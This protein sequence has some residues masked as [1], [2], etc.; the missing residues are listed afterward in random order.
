MAN[1]ASK[2]V[3]GYHD[4]WKA[5]I[6]HLPPGPTTKVVGR[7]IAV[8]DRQV[9]YRFTLH[10]HPYAR[11]L[12]SR[13]IVEGV[14][15]LQAADTER[16]SG[17]LPRPGTIRLALPSG[18]PVPLA[19]ADRV[20]ILDLPAGADDDL[21]AVGTTVTM[22]A[23]AP[24]AA[25]QAAAVT[26]VGVLDGLP[27]LGQDLALP[28]G[29]LVTAGNDLRVRITAET[30]VS[31]G[32]RTV[33]LPAGTVLLVRP[34]TRLTLTALQ[35]MLLDAPPR[36][37]LYGDVLLPGV[38]PYN[39]SY[40]VST[41]YPM[42]DLDFSSGGAYSIYNWELF[43][44]APLTIAMQL[45]KNQR[46]VEAQRWFHYIFD[47]TAD[48]DLP[49]PERFWKVL[50]FHSTQ[51]VSIEHLLTNL[52][53]GDDPELQHETSRS[54]DAWE[55]S[56]FQP[57]V[58]ARY[59]P[60]AYMY[61]AVM[62]YLDNLI[63]WGD[64]YFGEDTPE[65]VDEALQLY[66]LAS[67]IL[68]PRPQVVPR[69]ASRSSA[70]SYHQLRQE[71][72]EF[73][74]AMQQL[75]S[76]LPFD[77]MPSS[78]ADGSGDDARLAVLSGVARGI[79]FCVPRNDKL[80]GYWDT[81][82]DRLFKI[83]N[84]LNL[85]G[86]LRQLP[87]FSPPID[88]ALLARA[89]AAGV[90]VG[91][92][93][94]GLN[95]PMPLVRFAFLLQKA[96]E[97]AAEVRQLGAGI[98]SAMEKQDAEAFAR[99]RSRHEVATLD[100]A[101]HVRYDQLVA[102][103][104]EREALFEALRGAGIRYEHARLQL[105]KE[106]VRETMPEL[107]LQALLEMH[108]EPTEPVV[109]LDPIEYDIV[110]DLG[111]SQ[112]KIISGHEAAELSE[113][114]DAHRSQEIAIVLDM[115]A[116]FVSL[117]PEIEA[118]GKPLGLGVGVTIGGMALSRTLSLGADYFRAD[119]L[120]H[121]FRAGNS[122]RIAGYARRMQ[123]WQFQSNQ[124][125]SEIMHI[126]KQ[127]RAAQI[128]EAMAQHE[129]DNH[130]E[131]KKFAAEVQEFLEQGGPTDKVTNQSFYLWL[132]GELKT[133][134]AQA[135]Q[136]AYDTARKAER[137]LQRELGDTKITF[138]QP[139]YLAG[140]EG[141]M[142]ADRLMLDLRRMEAAYHDLNRREYELTK[143][144]SLL[145]LNPAALL[146]L[147]ATGTCTFDVPEALF[148][149]DGPGHY[150]RR[151]RSVAVTVPCVTGPYIGLGCKLTL[152]SSTIRT[153]AS[154]GIDHKY[155]RDEDDDL[156]FEDHYGNVQSIVTSSGQNDTGLLPPV[157]RD[158]RLLPFEGSGV[159][160]KWKIDLPANPAEGQPRLFDYQTIS[161]VILH[162]GYTAR[163]GGAELKKKASAYLSS[164]I[165]TSEGP[166]CRRLFAVKDEFPREWEKLISVKNGR[167]ALTVPLREE[168]YP[169]WSTGI[170]REIT[171]LELRTHGPA[172]ADAPPDG[173]AAPAPA[174]IQ[175]FLE[176][177][178]GTP[179]AFTDVGGDG[180]HEL[181][182][183]FDLADPPGP[184][185]ATGD[186]TLYFEGSAALRDLWV[187]ATW[188][189]KS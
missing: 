38:R 162:V 145:Q 184:V 28:D 75:E 42:S 159:F 46:F 36:P 19:P 130:R 149:L 135:F 82:A 8:Q 45:S 158:D 141:L 122:A 53:T 129:L 101:E 146:D 72:D 47:P 7:W 185:S 132:K 127:I 5:L 104:K 74:N 1:I 148:D 142:A 21:P 4:R 183:T 17:Y 163:D 95:Q 14:P 97:L 93:V 25:T 107:N 31:S 170:E 151:I 103:G 186:L 155:E 114:E 168:H 110:Q 61:K 147:R 143:H 173:L 79:Y 10:E 56:P 57:H 126:Y 63:A 177:T 99:L 65:S 120:S 39:P 66:V 27:A 91:A 138:L 137:A 90:D 71:L 12:A 73:G 136:L 131:Q 175:V 181:K 178:G 154:F 30:T 169:F 86:Q 139:G 121:S 94:S 49:A 59:R 96:Q 9:R 41:P 89:V 11:E 54:I 188:A 140:T 87:L 58:V 76:E 70:R 116:K 92:A 106:V 78:P 167:A 171:H 152:Q 62:A 189:K 60:Q 166:G 124:A 133:L 20:S 50:P 18:A 113:L 40:M 6:P 34:G 115:I 22:T 52:S 134:H 174:N 84:S 172:P 156:R 80:L 98:L 43:F 32:T 108:V 2:L 160:G 105:D 33:D 128:R 102:A 48:D 35:A 24:S 153:S 179:H 150:F 69:G 123:D 112:G 23:T 165:P 68:G 157:Q 118:S 64:S 26:L 83:H 182:A 111:A 125:A 77:L 15:G 13:A 16:T 37:V 67:Q 119:S 55:K 180:I 164:V 44:H 51:V 81:V 176:P 144:I 85:Q 88:P 3:V 109:P 187:V 161:D 29:S 117:I 100:L